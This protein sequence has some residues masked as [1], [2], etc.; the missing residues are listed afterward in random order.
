VPNFWVGLIVLWKDSIILLLLDVWPSNYYFSIVGSLHL[1]L[2]FCARVFFS[3]TWIDFIKKRLVCLIFVVERH[4]VFSRC[5]FIKELNYLYWVFPFYSCS[6]VV[7][8]VFWDMKHR[9]MHD[10]LHDSLVKDFHIL[11]D[12]I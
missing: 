4:M 3:C 7:L 2:G 9:G 12:E 10:S 8:L 6:L 5:L 11:K 1:M